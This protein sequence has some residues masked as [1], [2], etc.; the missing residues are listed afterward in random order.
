MLSFLK[1][2][3]QILKKSVTD[4]IADDAMK[5]SASLSYY[6][7]FS[8]TP[9]LV[10]IISVVSI[11]YGKD[12]VT[13]QIYYQ[14]SSLIG[15]KTASLI[16]D[17]LRN[18][19][20]SGTNILATIIGIITLIIGATGVFAE[21]QDSLNKIWSLKVEAQRGWVR[22]LM[23]RFI[24]F[25]MII[26]LGFLLLVSLILSASVEFLSQKVFG[27]RESWLWMAQFMNTGVVFIIITVLFAFILK[28]LPDAL[29]EW[30]DVWAGATFTAI[31]FLVGK[32]L[33]GYY[34]STSSVATVFGAAG[35]L[36]LLL[37][38]VYYSSAILFFG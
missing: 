4:F 28:F 26:S 24:S 19:E 23:N 17:A 15:E 38:W 13:G 6:T 10:I 34:L 22:Y 11:F 37:V 31:L 7:V 18:I 2:Y 9:V 25:S 35:S 30:R 5:Y 16:Q 1:L 20:L 8:I 29:I 3:W 21:L 32:F 12:A 14:F 33:I 27:A 36:A